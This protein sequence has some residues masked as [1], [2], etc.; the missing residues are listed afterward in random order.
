VGRGRVSDRAFGSALGR[1][2][3]A[4]GFGEARGAR[5]A[6]SSRRLHRPTR[7]RGEKV[8]PES[9]AHRRR[10]CAA[11]ATR[12][13]GAREEARKAASA[14]ASRGRPR[15]DL[16]S[17][18][19]RSRGP[20]RVSPRASAARALDR[21]RATARPPGRDLGS[22]APTAGWGALGRNA[23]THLRVRVFAV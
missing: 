20:S 9:P 6:V 11:A 8:K 21:L 12:V 14:R 13:S 22:E 7:R 1:A 23:W 4:R 17:A 5:G 19:E 3:S 2:R 15:G 16:R 18:I 10:P